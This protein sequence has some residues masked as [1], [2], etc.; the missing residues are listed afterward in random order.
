[1]FKPVPAGAEA[2]FFNTIGRWRNDRDW[3]IAARP[4]SGSDWL[5]RTFVQA[6]GQRASDAFWCSLTCSPEIMPLLSLLVR[7][8][9]MMRRA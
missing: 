5:K 6:V 7:W 8:S 3:W 1:D 4:L 2:D 9:R